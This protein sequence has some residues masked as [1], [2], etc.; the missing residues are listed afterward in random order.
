MYPTPK[1]FTAPIYPLPEKGVPYPKNFNNPHI[2]SPHIF[3]KNLMDPLP[4]FLNGL[5]V[6]DHYVTAQFHKG[7]VGG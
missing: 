6:C 1:I 7:G 3:N 5:H 2:P 4:G